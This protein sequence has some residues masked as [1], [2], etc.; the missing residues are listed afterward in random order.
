MTNT[1]NPQ[2][3]TLDEVFVGVYKDMAKGDFSLNEKQLEKLWSVICN[4][5][6][7]AKALITEVRIDELSRQL[8]SSEYAEDRTATDIKGRIEATIKQLKEKL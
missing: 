3:N 1:P 2:A 6:D 5:G 7:Q 4:R 8:E